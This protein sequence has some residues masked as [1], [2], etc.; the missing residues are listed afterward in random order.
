[1][2]CPLLWPSLFL[3]NL[4]FSPISSEPIKV[5][6]P[7]YIWVID[8][9]KATQ[10]HLTLKPICS[11]RV[12]HLLLEM[13]QARDFSSRDILKMWRALF[14]F[15]YGA[16]GAEAIAVKIPRGRRS[17]SCSDTVTQLTGWPWLESCW[18]WAAGTECQG[19]VGWTPQ[20]RTVAMP[21]CHSVLGIIDE[22]VP[23]TS[24]GSLRRSFGWE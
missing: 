12:C 2:C 18:G 21:G 5:A 13:V 17:G 22:P 24:T 4:I 6:N 1:M 3:C 15:R 20:R 16:S 19:W 9:N 11:N 14:I 23:G 8:S 7:K 10:I